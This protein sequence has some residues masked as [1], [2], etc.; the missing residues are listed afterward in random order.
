MG[1]TLTEKILANKA[2]VKTLSPGDFIEI[3]PDLGLANDITAPKR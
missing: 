1:L 3:E 2:G